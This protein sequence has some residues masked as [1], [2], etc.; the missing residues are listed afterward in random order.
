MGDTI[1]RPFFELK[2]EIPLGQTHK[3]IACWRGRQRRLAD[4]LDSGRVWVSVVTSRS[5]EMEGG[6]EKNVGETR[7]RGKERD[8]DARGRERG[9]GLFFE[10]F[11]A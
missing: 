1:F 11:R 3:A 5:R 9:K 10:N 7:E 4:L 8:R 6:R 2:I